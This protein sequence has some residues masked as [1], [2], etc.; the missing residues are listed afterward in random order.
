MKIKI[1]IIKSIYDFFFGPKCVHVSDGGTLHDMGR[2]KVFRCKRC[3][4]Y[5]DMT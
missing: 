2:V 5:L 1:T 4:Q 3:D